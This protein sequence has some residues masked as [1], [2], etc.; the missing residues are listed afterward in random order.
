MLQEGGL[1]GPPFCRAH[2]DV[3]DGWFSEL[4]GDEPG[5][6][7]V[8]VGGYGRREL[9]PGSDV[10]VLLLHRR[11]PGVAEVASRL[12]YPLWDAGVRLGHAVRT[13]K[14]ALALA[15]DDL[16][17]ATALLDAR[18]VVGDPDLAADVAAGAVRQWRKRRARWIDALGRRVDERH[19]AAGEVAF[20]L[21]PDLKEGKGG[22]R[23]VQSLRWAAAAEPEVVAVS[24]VVQ[25]AYDLLLTIRVELH[26]R[27]GRASDQL[28]LQEQDAVADGLGYDDADAL[29]AAV[30][31]AARTIAWAGD[32]TWRH[33]RA[34]SSRWRIGHRRREMVGPGLVLEPDGIGLTDDADLTDPSLVLRGAAAAAGHGTLLTRAT[35]ARLADDGAGP[36]D[37]W[38]TAARDA[39]VALLATGHR[40]IDVIESL[41]QWG[42]LLRLLPEW[43]GV[44]HRPQR[45]AYHRFTVDRHL[46]E[47]AANAAALTGGVSRPD[48]LLVGAWLHDIGKGRGGDHTEIG[49]DLMRTI[50]TRMGFGPADVATLVAMVEHHLLLPDVATRR[51]LEDP[52]T[53]EAVARAVGDVDT[54]QLLDALTEADSLATGASAWGT[55]KA[56]LVAELVGRTTRLLQGA[57][58]DAAPSLPTDDHRR[59]MAERRLVVEHDAG[60]LTVIAPDR[61]GLF[62]RVAGTIALHGLDVLGANVGA[63]EDGMAVEVFRV[64][65][66][67]GREPEW[68]RFTADLERALAGRLAL[69]ARLSERVRTY[70]RPSP[71]PAPVQPRVAI[72]NDASASATVIEVRAADA[73]GVLYRITKALAE[74]E[75]DVQS[76]KVQTLGH[77][78]VD[79]FYVHG[80]EGRKVGDVEYQVEIQRAV[81]AALS[82]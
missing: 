72:D 27:S 37:P 19:T 73:V 50:A 79:T 75:L 48:L 9:A 1:T 46:C 39:L 61:P 25:S 76:A 82:P 8:A 51:D 7:V 77:E 42:L 18:F 41:D 26:R 45:N 81:L 54:L 44:R 80:P 13:A 5:V 71:G 23:D 57:P 63:S 68:P 78:V 32:E 15:D 29:M 74:C 53:T 2:A 69:D 16:D 17:T 33:L 56:G 36:G 38:P 6:A 47:A 31:G 22:L 12:W 43:E 40:A 60:T 28:L 59:L 20:L 24:E 21:E 67:F 65:P 70:G 64:E 58:D 10:D 30:S 35:L 52:S 14:E 66:V 3:I 62:A 11:V 49:M 4:L 34:P 55:W